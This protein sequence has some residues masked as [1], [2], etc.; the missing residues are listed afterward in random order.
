MF[1]ANPWRLLHLVILIVSQQAGK[2]RNYPSLPIVLV[3]ELG[4]VGNYFNRKYGAYLNL[5]LII[6]DSFVF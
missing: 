3:A 4:N 1:S 2:E 5:Q 6:Q